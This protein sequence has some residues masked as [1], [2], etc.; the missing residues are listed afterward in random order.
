MSIKIFADC[1]D[2]PTMCRLARNPRISG[3]TTNPTLMRRAGVQD[4]RLFAKAA[5]QSLPD[6]PI[7]FEVL[8]DD[9]VEME[10]QAREIASW[11]ENVYV[12]VP[13]LTTERC[14]TTPVIGNLAAS[15]V[16]V[17]VTAVLTTQQ[18]EEVG[19]VLR[20]DTPCIISVFAG[21]IADTDQEPD[22]RIGEAIDVLWHHEYGEVLWASARGVH[23]VHLAERC[24]A[25]IITL[26]SDLIAKLDMRGRDLHELSLET[27]RQFRDDA[28]AAGYTI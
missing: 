10:R 22:Q 23:D 14:W 9:L 5:V 2:L 27:V 13:I 12:K 21:R 25:D 18:V 15:G 19:L 7:S 3:F 1:A 11:G 24:D 4:Y 8:A 26:P 16:K 6:Y 28:I 17:N 20:R